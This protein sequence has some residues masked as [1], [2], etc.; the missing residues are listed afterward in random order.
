MAMAPFHPEG[1]RED[2]T[3]GRLTSFV[4]RSP[5]PTIQ[6]VRRSVLDSI[7]RNEQRGT[8]YI[9]LETVNMEE[10]LAEPVIQPIHQRVL[11]ANQETVRSVGTA[12]IERVLES[13]HEDRRIAYSQY[14][15]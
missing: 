3:P 4:R 9:D 13:I 8:D 7:R 2:S 1:S 11:E 6:L 15:T 12:S 14:D 5:D 10:L